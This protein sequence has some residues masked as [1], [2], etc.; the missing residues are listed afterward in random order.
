[1]KKSILA[2]AVILNC[3]FLI[4]QTEF[5]ASKI[6]QG[7]I[8]GTAR[9]M[10]MAGAFGALGGDGSAI[11]DNPAGLGV[12]RTSELSGTINVSLQNSKSTW[13][14][15]LGNDN[16][17]NLGFT[18]FS[19]IKS[20]PTF[21]GLNGNAGLLSS[22]WSF[23]YNRLKSFN[24]NSTIKNNSSASSIT[25]Y[26]AYF[27]GNIASA[28]L[29]SSNNPYDN[30]NIPWISELAY[31]G[32]L[33]NEV[34]PG[35]ANAWSS[36]LNSGELVTPTYTLQETGYIDE[37][38]IGWAGNFSNKFYLGTTLN[39]QS[40]DYT[41]RS[42]Y[43]ELFGAGGNM[44][45]DN[46]VNTSGTGFNLNVGAIIRPVDML[47]LGVSVHTPTI[48]A[49][50]DNNYATL[51]YNIDQTTYGNVT[52]PTGSSDYKLN[53]PWKFNASAALV[54]GQKGLISAEYD[55]SM[56]TY[57]KFY[58]SDGNA[59]VFADENAG[60]KDMLKDVKTI[61]I[62]G[63]YKLSDNFS[64]R[65]GYANMS[66]GTNNLQADKLMRF[67]TVRTDPE[68]FQ[69]NRTDY[70][71]AGFGY[72]ETNWF[73]DFAYMNKVLDETFYPYNSNSLTVEASP[74][75]VKTTNNNIILTIGFKF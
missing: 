33:I 73:I 50:S 17:S 30:L 42:R 28:D 16:L 18:N 35:S 34:S 74:A 20:I 72:R 36:L 68:Y 46:T 52:T 9:Y 29:S 13:N 40:I 1:M 54:I 14:N 47:R 61:K 10:S 63:E 67:N 57:S 24:R 64:L 38:S 44:T 5:D 25:D 62:G 15:T 8:N 7:D 49:L 22:N 51:N 23:T 75:S 3:S 56:N 27:S 12:Y 53:N 55:Y 37:Y 31:Q 71:T 69:N 21:N 19:Y 32:Y 60:I 43:S 6:I 59:Q 70:I 65:A 41:A 39:L 58:D 2:L 26:M 4:A 66:A 11:K 48:Y 45:L